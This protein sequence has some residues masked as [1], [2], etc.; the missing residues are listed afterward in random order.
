MSEPFR[1][2]APPLEVVGHAAVSLFRRAAIR[3]RGL[4]ERR[5]VLG[6][7]L[8]DALVGL[9]RGFRECASN[10]CRPIHELYACRMRA[11][12]FSASKKPSHTVLWLASVFLPAAVTL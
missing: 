7:L 3:A 8:D 9:V 12:R 4:V 1:I 5:D 6:Q 10:P 11:T 2:G